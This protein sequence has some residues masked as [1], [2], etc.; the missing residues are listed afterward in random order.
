MLWLAIGPPN[1]INIYLMIYLMAAE[2]VFCFLV[3]RMFLTAIFDARNYGILVSIPGFLEQEGF[4]PAV[5]NA[6][7]VCKL[8]GN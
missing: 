1:R 8:S 4:F 3:G 6:F 2:K 5:Q 7:L